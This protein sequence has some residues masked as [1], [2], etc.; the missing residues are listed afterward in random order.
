MSNR[1]RDH[2]GWFTEIRGA[3]TCRVECAPQSYEDS[4]N[5]NITES[6]TRWQ[7]CQADRAQGAGGRTGGAQEYDQTGQSRQ[8]RK[9]GGDQAGEANRESRQVQSASTGESVHTPCGWR[10]EGDQNRKTRKNRGAQGGNGEKGRAHAAG[11]GQDGSA[12][13][14]R[15]TCWRGQAPRTVLHSALAV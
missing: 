2:P 3:L 4:N 5:G 1:N 8:T 10:A 6:Q 9:G 14:C 11:V 15:R 7:G 13:G 12:R